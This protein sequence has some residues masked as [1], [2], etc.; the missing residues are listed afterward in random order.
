MDEDDNDPQIMEECRHRKD[1]KSWKKAIQDELDSLN[2]RKVF[3]P[4]T[5]T[6]K[7]VKPVGHKHELQVEGKVDVKQIPSNQNLA[8]LFTNPLPAKV[9]KQ[10]VHDIG[11]RHL[12]DICLN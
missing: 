12:K 9:F 7:G 6:P 1:W 2:K 11:T 5:P 10:L 3:G 8:D 4:I